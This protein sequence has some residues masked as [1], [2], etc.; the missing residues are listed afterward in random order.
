MNKL[1]K[2]VLS[3]LLVNSVMFGA[4][5]ATETDVAKEQEQIVRE[6]RLIELQKEELNLIKK[7]I[8]LMEN[9]PM[10]QTLL[11]D[12]LERMLNSSSGKFNQIIKLQ[13]QKL[14][15]EVNA[16]VQNELKRF[17][18][19]NERYR[20]EL[21]TIQEQQIE[22]IK[23]SFQKSFEEIQKLKDSIEMKQKQNAQ[24]M[25]ELKEMFVKVQDK[26][27]SYTNYIDNKFSLKAVKAVNLSRLLLVK[28]TFPIKYV[29][30]FNSK[31]TITVILNTNKEY[32]INSMVTERCRIKDL[33]DR[34]IEVECI[35]VNNK[36]YNNVMRLEIT[37]EKDDYILNA[38]KK[39]TS[40][41]NSTYGEKPKETTNTS[42]RKRVKI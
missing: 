1:K 6:S 37:E 7:D 29:K 8:K 36:I 21:K 32:K 41:N 3:A 30:N 22:N 35:D 13:S 40:N 26:M 16:Q 9:N 23:L 34:Q 24:T 2:I 25:N 28:D 10:V 27:D 42:T 14:S 33:S 31:E 4:Q 19:S 17:Q 39:S 38:I 11:T 20:Q 15:N 18:Q 5:I 12:F